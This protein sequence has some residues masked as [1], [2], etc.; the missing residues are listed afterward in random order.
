M[1]TNNRASRVEPEKMRVQIPA[2]VRPEVRERLA[3]IAR[4][5]GLYSPKR[6]GEPNFGRV[7]DMLVDKLPPEN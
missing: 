4:A 6:K 2:R 7:I 1:E 5:H 3:R